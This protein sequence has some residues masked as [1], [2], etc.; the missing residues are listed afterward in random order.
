MPKLR[1]NIITGDWVVISPERAKR[2]E[3]FIIEKKEVKNKPKIKGTETDNLYVIPN[4]VPAFVDQDE[5]VEEGGDFYPSYKSLG[6]HEVISFR[7]HNIELPELK[8]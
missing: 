6:A 1:Q 3:D 2:P 8:N 7:D 4:K 5:V